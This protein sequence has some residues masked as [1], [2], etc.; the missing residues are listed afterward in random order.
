MERDGD[1][2]IAFDVLAE[3]MYARTPEIRRATMIPNASQIK[4][5]TTEIRNGLAVGPESEPKQV[6]PGNGNSAQT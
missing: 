1:G 3:R 6:K 5:P 2:R 4:P